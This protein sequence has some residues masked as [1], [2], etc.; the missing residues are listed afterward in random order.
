MAIV[1]TGRRFA[2]E[3]MIADDGDGLN[4]LAGREGG[5]ATVRLPVGASEPSKLSV[6][7]K[8]VGPAGLEPATRP[9]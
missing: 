2:W 9:L 8:M 4:T 1:R 5:P 6:R 7:Q 3:S